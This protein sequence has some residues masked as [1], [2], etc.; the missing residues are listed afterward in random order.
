MAE[1]EPDAPAGEPGGAACIREREA[2]GGMRVVHDMDGFRVMLAHILD[3][4]RVEPVIGVAGAADG[5][6]PV[7]SPS[8]VRA[9]IGPDAPIYYA[10]DEFWLEH[11]DQE[12]GSRLALAPAAARIWWPGLTR[13]SDPGDHPLVAALEAEDPSITLAEF[14]RVFHLSRPVV[15]REIRVLEE[16]L[17]LA[18]HLLSQTSAQ[19]AKAEQLLRDA[20]VERHRIALR[21]CE[22]DVEKP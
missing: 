22:R 2:L 8:G 4:R 21:A 16:Q 10:E 17:A 19:L 14:A 18:E 5:H 12:L 11:L 13:G 6:E 1:G 3:R 9:T 15:R 7:I 20:H